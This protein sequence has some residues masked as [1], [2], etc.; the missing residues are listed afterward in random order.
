MLAGTDPKDDG[1]RRFAELLADRPGPTV[2]VWTAVDVRALAARRDVASLTA[3]AAP[4]AAGDGSAA[5]PTAGGADGP[6]VAVTHAGKY[7][8]LYRWLRTQ[9]AATLTL[10]FGQVEEVLGFPLPASSRAHVPHWHSY[11]GSAVARAIIDAG[12]KATKV[13]LTDEE[14]TM[15]RVTP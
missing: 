7:A 12:W 14:L 6:S 3:V 9:E 1:L 5:N 2:L 4:A 8:P 13:H 11:D 15:V 10:T